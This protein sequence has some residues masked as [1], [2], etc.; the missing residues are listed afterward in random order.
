MAVPQQLV[1]TR[2]AAQQLVETS[3]A[4][5]AFMATLVA[6]MEAGQ[7][8]TQALGVSAEA[9][10]RTDIKERARELVRMAEQILHLAGMIGHSGGPPRLRS[11]PAPLPRGA[12][13]AAAETFAI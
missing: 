11:L 9:D 10:V 8:P 3:N 6:A 5:Q 4:F 13:P 1:A 12:S 2:A 7:N